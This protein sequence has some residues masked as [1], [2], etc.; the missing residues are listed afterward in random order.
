M[1]NL[2]KLKQESR[3]NV[4]DDCYTP[5]GV[6][7][8]LIEFLEENIFQNKEAGKCEKIW[9]CCDFGN[10]FITKDFRERGYDVFGSGIDETSPFKHDYLK[11]DTELLSDVC[12]RFIVT[13]PPYSLKDKFLEKAIFDL[14]NGFIKGVAFL[15]PLSSLAG[16]KRSILFLE[17]T[18]VHYFDMDVLVFDRRIDFT[19]K[20]ANYFDVA[21]FVFSPNVG[22]K[23]F[24]FIN[25][26][27]E[28]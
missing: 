20:G 28:F 13:N 11:G 26:E 10:S 12:D 15:L 27:K 23:E 14:S 22:R 3:K 18:E 8:P 5:K 2:L 19:G 7:K 16:V 1:S 24:H 6:A 21:W 9:E 17:A 4:F 25:Y